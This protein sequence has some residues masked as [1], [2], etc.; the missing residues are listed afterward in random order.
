[1]RAVGA[2]GAGLP[3][4]ALGGAA[5]AAVD[6]AL[7]AVL[8]QVVAGRR[9]ADAGGADAAVA[10]DRDAADLAGAA[11]GAGGAAAVDVGLAGVLDGVRAVGDAGRARALVAE[12]VAV[13][14]AA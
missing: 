11:R 10:V 2:H 5:A 8:H 3:G 6:V 7:G 9:D 1:A 13:D 4:G 12:A 14:R